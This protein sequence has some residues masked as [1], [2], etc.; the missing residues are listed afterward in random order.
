MLALRVRMKVFRTGMMA[1]MRKKLLWSTAMV[2]AFALAWSQEPPGGI[3]TSV[4]PTGT[5][6]LAAQVRD[7]DVV[8]LELQGAKA[9]AILKITPRQKALGTVILFPDDYTTPEDPMF[10]APIRQRLPEAGWNT[11]ALSIP[12]PKFEEAEPQEAPPKGASGADPLTE[13]SA[14]LKTYF[15]AAFDYLEKNPP[16]ADSK[17][18]PI[19]VLG[20]GSGAA[21]SLEYAADEGKDDV[22][23]LI[24]VSGYSPKQDPRFQKVLKKFLNIKPWC[25]MFMGSV[26]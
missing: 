20:Y 7:G 6:L 19:V 16:R 10:L 23:S 4:E 12:L 24:L 22:K 25:L 17:S 2:A 5:E 1:K 8:W 11:L 18:A 14:L 21:W 3:P 13:R 9:L 15:K 26:I